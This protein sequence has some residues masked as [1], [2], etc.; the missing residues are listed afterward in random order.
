MKQF[1]TAIFLTLA[2]STN[3]QFSWRPAGDRL[4]S[5]FTEQV[6]PET[7]LPEY[8]RPILT[9]GEWQNLNGLWYY[10][11]VNED[12][13]CPTEYD[14]MILVPYPLESS[15]SGVQRKM[16]RDQV[17]WYE[18]TFSIPKA[19]QDRDILLHFGA[20]DHEAVVYVNGRRV[21]SHVGGYTAFTAN[22]TSAL[23][24]GDNRL[25]VRVIEASGTPVSLASGRLC[26]WN[27][28]PNSI[29]L[30]S[31]RLQTLTLHALLLM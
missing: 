30:I 17:L 25:T 5:A 23:R 9:R 21:A 28:S 14:G 19:W 22:I 27:P 20:V 24:D 26:G 3:A 31:V 15:L 8:P 13:I 7:P 16:R 12:D 4:K 10:A 6:N 18:R 2:L 29:S 11:I 1:L